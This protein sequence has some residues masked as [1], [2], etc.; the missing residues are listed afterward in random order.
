MEKQS[1]DVLFMDLM[2]PEMDGFQATEQIRAAGHT[3]PIVAMSADET[4]ETKQ[5]AFE[6]GMND[7]L[8]KPTRVESIKHLLIKLFS[9][10]I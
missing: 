9:K 7:Y 10:T 8:M 6:A 2:M 1:F 3:L 4:N 5:A